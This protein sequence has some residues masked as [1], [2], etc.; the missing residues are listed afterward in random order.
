MVSESKT[1]GSSKGTLAGR[2]GVEPVATMTHSACSRVS[3]PPV[4]ATTVC[5]AFQPSLAGYQMHVALADPL[6]GGPP[7]LFADLA[8]PGSDG[9]VHHLR[10]RRQRNPVDLFLLKAAEVDSGLPKGLGR[11]A[12]A[13]DNGAANDVPL[14]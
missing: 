10:R 8:G 9:R 7:E 3:A 6:Q 1:H 12:T 2:S 14:H 5:S 4:R 13:G 11:R